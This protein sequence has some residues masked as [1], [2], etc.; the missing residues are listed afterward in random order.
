MKTY[1]QMITELKG[2]EPKDK[3]FTSKEEMDMLNEHFGLEKMSAY[4]LQNLRDMFMALYFAYRDWF[5]CSAMWSI[6]A[7]IDHHKF[8]KGGEI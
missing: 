2:Y 1:F 7:V 4:E 3:H 6:T 5:S 8:Q